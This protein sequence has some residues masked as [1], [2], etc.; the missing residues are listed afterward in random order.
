MLEGVGESGEE[1]REVGR[2]GRRGKKTGR[3]Q[4]R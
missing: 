2:D 4:W 1:E 3:E